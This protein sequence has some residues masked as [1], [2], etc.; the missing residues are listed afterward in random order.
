MTFAATSAARFTRG[1]HCISTRSLAPIIPSTRVCCPAVDRFT[2]TSRTV[3]SSPVTRN[4]C[5]GSEVTV[6]WGRCD[7]ARIFGEAGWSDTAAHKKFVK[8]HVGVAHSEGT[9]S[10]LSANYAGQVDEHVAQFD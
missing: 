5:S 10:I 9:V 6:V 3:T 7:G 1:V 8:T 2:D 4:F